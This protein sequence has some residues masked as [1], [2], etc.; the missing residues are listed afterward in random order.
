M[1]FISALPNRPHPHRPSASHAD[2]SSSRI[3]GELVHTFTDQDCAASLIRF[4]LCFF[5]ISCD[6]L[7]RVIRIRLVRSELARLLKSQRTKHRYEKRASKPDR[8]RCVSPVLIC[9]HYSEA[10]FKP[11]ASCMLRESHKATHSCTLACKGLPLQHQRS[12]KPG[13]S[14]R[15]LGFCQWIYTDTKAPLTQDPFR[16]PSPPVTTYQVDGNNT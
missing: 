8:W 1:L 11:R 2:A 6:Q 12:S 13:L 4:K 9:R 7:W 15:Q 16:S 10:C 5:A 3:H 14:C